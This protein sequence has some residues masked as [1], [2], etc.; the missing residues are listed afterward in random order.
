MAAPG[1]AIQGMA[2]RAGI[3]NAY[4]SSHGR[5]V[6]LRRKRSQSKNG[7]RAHFG[8][9]NKGGLS[10]RKLEEW[11]D[12]GWSLTR[13]F[14]CALFRLPTGEGEALSSR[15]E[16]SA[17]FLICVSA[18]LREGNPCRIEGKECARRGAERDMRG[19]MFSPEQEEPSAGR[20]RRRPPPSPRLRR[21]G[22]G[23]REMALGMGGGRTER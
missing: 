21:T 22:G 16:S 8:T 15:E 1:A 7:R 11:P 19:R 4:H 10:L 9:T 5:S 20:R 3:W 2:N 23:S 6:I 14:A 17:D 12:L 13:R 18:G